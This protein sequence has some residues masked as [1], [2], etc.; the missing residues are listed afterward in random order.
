MECKDGRPCSHSGCLHHISHPCEGCGRVGGVFPKDLP[1]FDWK[2]L[3]KK[4]VKLYV[5]VDYADEPDYSVEVL[6]AS[7]N[8]KLYMLANQRVESKNDGIQN[9]SCRGFGLSESP[10]RWHKSEDGIE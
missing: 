8:G 4:D 7:Y 2:E 6:M 9:D 5:G 10:I 1:V 3:H